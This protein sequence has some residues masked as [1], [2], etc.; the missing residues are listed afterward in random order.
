MFRMYASNS[1][2]YTNLILALGIVREPTVW[3]LLLQ[4]IL[5][6]MTL[7]CLFLIPTWIKNPGR[8]SFPQVSTAQMSSRILAKASS[9]TA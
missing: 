5:A 9:E 1:H 7:A 4:N 2:S 6:Y 3:V 8:R